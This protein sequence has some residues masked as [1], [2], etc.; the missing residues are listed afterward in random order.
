MHGGLCDS[1]TDYL[2]TPGVGS[3]H[4]VTVCLLTRLVGMLLRSTDGRLRVRPFSFLSMYFEI[5][6]VA[7]C[8]LMANLFGRLDFA[9]RYPET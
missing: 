5:I 9:A 1:A 7:A 2:C 3:S 6:V 8:L 4:S